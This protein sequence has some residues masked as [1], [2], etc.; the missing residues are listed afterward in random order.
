MYPQGS[1]RCSTL[2]H[3]RG[4]LVESDWRH[5][6]WRFEWILPVNAV[7]ILWCDGNI[8]GLEH[9]L[10]R[11]NRISTVRYLSRVCWSSNLKT[12]KKVFHRMCVSYPHFPKKK[13]LFSCGNLRRVNNVI[14]VGHQSLV[15]DSKDSDQNISNWSD[16][17][18]YQL[19]EH[20]PST[21]D[22]Q[23]LKPSSLLRNGSDWNIGFQ[24][25]VSEY[26]LTGNTGNTLDFIA[27]YDFNRLS[28]ISNNYLHFIVH[29]LAIYSE[30][31]IL[32][33]K[34]T[35]YKTI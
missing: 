16:S 7:D 22:W 24:S 21:L 31:L 8:R 1:R 13:N 32:P 15:L 29:V 9:I 2:I 20:Q 4:I 5:C 17:L 18:L 10:W 35:E 27:K 3:R 34:S 14:Y 6:S 30:Y 11:K 12:L 19:E 28:Q 33:F 26:I 23:D 25:K